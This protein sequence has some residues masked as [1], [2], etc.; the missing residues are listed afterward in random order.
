MDSARGR[1]LKYVHQ[2]SRLAIS[3]SIAIMEVTEIVMYDKYVIGD[4]QGDRD[5]DRAIRHMTA[6]KIVWVTLYDRR[7]ERRLLSDKYI[8][9]VPR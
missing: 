4:H 7:P 5:R 2:P 3:K 9:P 1:D 8:R 6:I